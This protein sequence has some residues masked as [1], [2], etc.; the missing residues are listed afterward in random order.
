MAQIEFNYNGKKT[1]IQSKLNEKMKNIFQSFVNKVQVDKNKVFFL[2]NG[3]EFNQ[4]D[5]ELSCEKF[6]NSE[7]KK[8]KILVNEF[9]NPIKMI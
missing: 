4:A 1:I 3:K 6:I 2:Y 5:E 9:D 7:D 8:M